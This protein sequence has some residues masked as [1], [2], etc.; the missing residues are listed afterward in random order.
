MVGHCRQLTQ[1]ISAGKHTKSYTNNGVGFFVLVSSQNYF[2]QLTSSKTNYTRFY[3]NNVVGWSCQLDNLNIAAICH[4]QNSF[5]PD[6]IQ[7]AGIGWRCSFVNSNMS[8]I[9]RPQ[10]K[11]GIPG[12]ETD[13]I[14]V[15]LQNIVYHQSNHS[16]QLVSVW[17][18][19]Q[20]ML[21]CS[22]V[23]TVEHKLVCDILFLT[24][25]RTVLMNLCCMSK[26]EWFT[27]NYV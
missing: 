27:L 10:K 16:C 14:R 3:T 8:A 7:L 21:D 24:Y 1:I 2:C 15:L 18:L 4:P 23:K 19:C 12:R 9:Y 25:R 5:I 11:H 22:S 17:F 26:R 20:L 6:S 13:A